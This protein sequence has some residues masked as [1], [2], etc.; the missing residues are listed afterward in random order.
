MNGIAFVVDINQICLNHSKRKSCLK[1]VLSGAPTSR[2]TI[3]RRTSLQ[4]SSP[5]LNQ[6]CRNNDSDRSNFAYLRG[7]RTIAL[8]GKIISTRNIHVISQRNL[9]KASTTTNDSEP[10]M[11][12][13][14][15]F[16]SNIQISRYSV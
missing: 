15:N 12:N 10:E 3:K 4:K 1:R 5:K 11:T 9:L 14:Q 13:C 16:Y 7:E 2:S 6:Q 8:Y